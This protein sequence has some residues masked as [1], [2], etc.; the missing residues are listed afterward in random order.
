MADDF[1]TLL[2]SFGF[3]SRLVGLVLIRANRGFMGVPGVLEG[4]R[5]R[6]PSL[7]SLERETITAGRQNELKAQYDVD[8]SAGLRMRSQVDG[9]GV[10]AKS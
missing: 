6:C 7:V 5:G 3:S 1:S 4:V 9:G 2:S 8:P 10:E